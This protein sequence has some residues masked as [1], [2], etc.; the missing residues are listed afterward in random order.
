M[1]SSIQVNNSEQE[2]PKLKVGVRRH[3]RAINAAISSYV[4]M[5]VCV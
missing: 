1:K 3:T 2:N 4:C 5:Y